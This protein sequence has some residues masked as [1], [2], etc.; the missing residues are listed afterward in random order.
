MKNSLLFFAAFLTITSAFAQA[1]DS[2]LIEQPDQRTYFSKTYYNPRDNTYKTITSAGYVHYLASDGTLK[3]IDTNL[4]LDKSGAYYIIDSGLYNVAFAAAIGK[5]NWDI[6]YEVPRP[7]Q[8]KFYDPGK[9]PAPV[10]RIRWKILSYGYWDS[11]RNVYQVIHNAGMATPAVSGNTI[12]YQEIFSGIDVRYT[13][14][15]T[16]VKE[17]FV[18][19]QSTRNTLPDPTRYGL[20]RGNTHF[21]VAMEFLLT[22]NNLNVFARRAAGKTSIK[23]GD[24]FSFNGDDPIDFEDE[25]STLHFFFPKDYAHA[26]ADSVTVSSTRVSLRRYFYSQGGKHYMLMGVPWN[27]VNS[28]PE[29]DL[30]IDPT[31]TVGTSDDVWLED[32]FN[33]DGHSVGL[34]IG[35]AADPFPKKRT[36]I[37]FDV[38][39]YGIPS[40]ATVLNAQLKMCYY[41][42]ANGGSGTWVNRWVQAHQILVNWNETQATRVNRLTSTPWNVQYVGLNDI[43]AKSTFESTLLFQQDYPKWKSWDLT[44]LTK[45]WLDGTATNYG[46]VLW[47]TNEATN[48]YDLRFRSSENTPT[49]ERPYLEVTWSQLPRTVYFLKDHLGSI[50]ATVQDTSTAPVVGYDDY[51]PWGYILAGRSSVASGW[52][53]QAGI[54]KNKFTGKEWDDEFGLNW[55]YFGARYYDPLIGRWMSVDPLAEKHPDFTPY[56]YV[57]N[58]PLRLFDP[59][60]KQVDFYDRLLIDQGLREREYSEQVITDLHKAEDRGVLIGA[61]IGIGGVLAATAGK[62]IL[63]N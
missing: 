8:P 55:N 39:G 32:T 25:H 40:G 3:D 54:I 15:A 46:V 57:L 12:D 44:S 26:V 16:S 49:N 60:G 14:N 18:L 11:Q 53:S 7:L 41:S 37:K 50:R 56:N 2:V 13:C 33:Y 59:D 22:P 21:V 63:P 42:A 48:G 35:I 23:Q 45:K 51:D 5:G 29:G 62:L 24:N 19:S 4:R 58:N 9:P 36:I 30:I 10:T 47:A 43:D 20:S 38:A 28:A 1:P 6:A 61:A 34:L 31:T 17:E 52:G 27:W